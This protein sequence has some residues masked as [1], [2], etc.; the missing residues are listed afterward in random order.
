[1]RCGCTLIVNVPHP[2]KNLHLLPREIEREMVPGLALV[3]AISIV[4]N[5]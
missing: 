5:V 4:Y 2:E 1:M 3:I